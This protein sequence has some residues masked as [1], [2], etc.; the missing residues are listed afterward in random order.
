MRAKGV[1]R[2]HPDLSHAHP[3]PPVL[4]SP[5]CL[6][7]P[8]TRHTLQV[9]FSGESLTPVYRIASEKSAQPAL[10]VCSLVRIHQFVVLVRSEPVQRLSS[11]RSRTYMNTCACVVCV[12]ACA[13]YLNTCM[14]G[15]CALLQVATAAA[16]AALAA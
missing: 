5:V 13:C 4:S 8:Y 14:Y 10:C 1:S 2:L 16:S 9:H 3:S 11:G 7:S 12:R 6:S 15:A